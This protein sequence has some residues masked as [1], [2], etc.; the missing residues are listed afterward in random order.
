MIGA[1][2]TNPNSLANLD[3]G[4]EIRKKQA[5]RSTFTLKPETVTILRKLGN[6][7]GGIDTMVE[8]I[9]KKGLAQEVFFDYAHDR[10]QDQALNTKDMNDR[11]EDSKPQSQSMKDRIE[12]LESQLEA[13]VKGR[14]IKL[15]YDHRIAELEERRAELL[16]KVAELRGQVVPLTV[17]RDTL[18]ADNSRLRSHISSLTAQL[19]SVGSANPTSIKEAIAI[20]N[21]LIATPSNK[22]R[23]SKESLREVVRLLGA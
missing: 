8:F 6:M 16:K 17:E 15:D 11:R 13:A 22:G 10:N 1:M 5:I 12:E 14:A 18:Q 4:R 9:Q 3:K 23:V 2:R 19:E 7:S 20:L 21:T